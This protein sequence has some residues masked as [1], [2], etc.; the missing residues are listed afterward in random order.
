MLC[1]TCILIEYLRGNIKARDILTQHPGTNLAMSTV[2]MMELI[3][4]AFNKREISAIKKAFAEFTV[5]EINEQISALAGE[6]IEKFSK[7]HNL[8]IP[9]ALIAATAIT[10]QMPLLTYN[11]ADFRFIPG[12]VIQ[13]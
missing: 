2:T 10:K 9:D 11:L 8:L 7:S 1:D 12:L 6:L 13:E 5:I 4:G 3:I